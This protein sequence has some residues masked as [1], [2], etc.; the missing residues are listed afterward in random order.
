SVQVGVNGTPL[1][2][3]FPVLVPGTSDPWLAGMPDGSTASM[4]DVAPAQSP[5]LVPD[6]AVNAGDVLTFTAAGSVNFFPS[7][8]VWAGGT[9]SSRN[10]GTLTNTGFMRIAQTGVLS[11]LLEAPLNNSGTVTQT[12]GRLFIGAAGALNN[13]GLYDLQTDN[14]SVNGGVF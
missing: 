8:F 12:G 10:G 4:G 5:A 13:H 14:P 2:Q 7:M 1:D 3:S 11:V 9:I 6:L